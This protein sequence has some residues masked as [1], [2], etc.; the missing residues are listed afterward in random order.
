MACHIWC[1]GLPPWWLSQDTDRT[2]IHLWGKISPDS[3]SKIKEI[4]RWKAGGKSESLK[5]TFAKFLRGGVQNLPTVVFFG[6]IVSPHPGLDPTMEVPGE[7]TVMSILESAPTTATKP[8]EPRTSPSK[9]PRCRYA[10]SNF[11]KR[12]TNASHIYSYIFVLS[13]KI[14]DLTAM[15]PMDVAVSTGWPLQC[16]LHAVTR[17]LCVVF[18]LIDIFSCS[19]QISSSFRPL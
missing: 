6:Q 16:R 18:T 17:T 2:G 12:R 15:G 3:A 9:I 10:V 8:D 5:F 1:P 4:I 13:F 14:L 7:K 11:S 19:Y